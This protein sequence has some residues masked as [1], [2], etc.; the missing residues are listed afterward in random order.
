MDQIELKIC[1][2]GRRP[3]CRRAKRLQRSKAYAF[4]VVDVTI[5]HLRAKAGT[6][7]RRIR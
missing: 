5:S 3:H 7:G 6:R 1:S 2:K 4:E